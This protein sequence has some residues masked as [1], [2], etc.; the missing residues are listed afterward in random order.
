M[1]TDDQRLFITLLSTSKLPVHRMNNFLIFYVKRFWIM[2][3]IYYKEKV[4]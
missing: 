4:N 3:Y 1:L 2:L